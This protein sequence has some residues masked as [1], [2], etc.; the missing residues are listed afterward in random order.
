MNRVIVTSAGGPAA[1]N[2][3]QNLKLA[4]PTFVVGTDVDPAMLML[5]SADVKAVVHHPS[6]A[7]NFYISEMNHLADKH[8][9]SMLL[10]V[11]DREIYVASIN[12]KLLPAMSI[13]SLAIVRLCRDKAALYS[14]MKHH[15]LSAPFTIA[16]CSNSYYP[17][18]I[19]DIQEPYWLRATVG[20]G[21][22]LAYKVENFQEV[23]DILHFHR[24]K[25][26]DF[27]LTKYLSGRNFCWTSLWVNGELRLSVTKQRLRWVYN[28]IGTTA[29]QTTV[30]DTR[31]SKL[32]EE[33]V[34]L[35][36]DLY[37]PDMTALMM[38][39][40]KEDVDDG[41]PY[42]TEINAGRT[43]TV[44]LWFTLASRMIYGD[45]QVNFHHQL[46]RA[47]HDRGL[48]P[49]KKRDSLPEDVSFIRHIDMGSVLMYKKRQIR[50]LPVSIMGK[51][52]PVETELTVPKEVKA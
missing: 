44:S 40:L 22:F 30:H 45:H 21:G 49:C 38:I 18:A 14:F 3:V 42:I 47:H 37:E 46:L 25:H 52:E 23:K 9:C 34:K 17:A 16:P 33:T 10:P 28:R 1:E 2:I 11:G 50:I 51:L 41:K 19:R 27:M 39:D 12:K 13:P 8:N 4:E 43:G 6:E 36:V 5:S 32:C 29:V 26:R 31:V 48:V 15:R 35:L 24:N 7:N 20:A